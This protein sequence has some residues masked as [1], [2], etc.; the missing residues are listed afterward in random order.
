M[1][2]RSSELVRSSEALHARVRAFART[3]PEGES[4]ERLALSIAQFQARYS[5]SFARLVALHGGRLDEVCRIPAVPSDAFRAARVS[6][7]EASLDCV[8]FV[9]SGTTDSLRGTHPFR[10]TRTYTELAVSFGRAALTR[11]GERCTVVALAPVPDHPP[12]SSL[13]FMFGAFMAKLD[14]RGLDG[15]VF[16]QTARDRWLLGPARVDLAGLRLASEIA[17][18]RGEPLLVLS[19]SL[20]LAALLDQLDGA[21]LELA[22]GS[23]VMQTGG[24]KG[25]R[26]TLDVHALR[27]GVSVALGVPEAAV[28]SEYGMTELSSQ[29]Y[30]GTCPGALLEGPPDV[31]LAPPWLRVTPVDPISLAPVR[32]GEVG[33]ARFVDLA[34]VDSAIAVV[35]RD[36][37]RARGP[38]I[39]LLGREI[40][41]PPRGCSL[42]VEALFAEAADG[43]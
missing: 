4:F 14:G 16:S 39:E 15:G 12:S 30:E 13:T 18:R 21:C 1:S 37:I 41:A 2:A 19:T 17:R 5:P 31:Y 35:T 11:S 38:G 10:T 7:H 6:V 42:T 26:V 8:R 33:L 22:P 34:N 40:G 3:F 29:L 25:R 9:T 23:V 20:A 28:V 43:R 24:P 27:V 32:S 36:R